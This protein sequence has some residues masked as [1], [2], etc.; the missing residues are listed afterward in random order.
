MSLHAA[1]QNRELEEYMKSVS[2]ESWAISNQRLQKYIR[3]EIDRPKERAP[4]LADKYR[5]N[6]AGRLGF[7]TDA[8]YKPADLARTNP[9][10]TG[11]FVF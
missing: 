11:E 2:Q 10:V 5:L 6:T 1:S 4:R 8:K 7:E 9:I 3:E